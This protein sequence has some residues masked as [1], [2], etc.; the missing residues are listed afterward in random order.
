VAQIVTLVKNLDNKIGNLLLFA[1]SPSPLMRRVSIH[2]IL[3]E[4]LLFSGQ[5][6]DREDISLSVKYANRDPIIY[7]DPEM[8]KQVFLNLIL[9]ALQAMPGGGN[10]CIET[11]CPASVDG[12][13]SVE[14]I[15]SDTGIGI[16]KEDTERIFEPFFGTREGCCGVGL[17][18]VH[19]IVTMH[20][21]HVRVENGAQGG[22]VFNISFPLCERD[23]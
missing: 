6:I 12:N 3:K 15:F 16:P 10:L 4:I 18:V 17:T 22:A 13:L 21:G 9:N 23:S 20:G 11:G 14:I 2:K 5:I 1:I 7:G 19:N 8:L